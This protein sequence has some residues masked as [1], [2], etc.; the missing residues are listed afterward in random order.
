MKMEHVPQ[1]S[2]AL[3]AAAAGVLLAGC[4]TAPIDGGSTPA[5]AV[6]ARATVGP[7]CGLGDA[8][9]A[10][11]LTVPTSAGDY[12]QLKVKLFDHRVENTR[13]TLPAR[14]DEPYQSGEWC[15]AEFNCRDLTAATVVF[16]ARR[17]DRSIPVTIDARL[18]DGTRFTAT[19]LARPRPGPLPQCG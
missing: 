11:L 2:R 18:P 12:P 6:D 16:G 3:L 4:S 5:A 13:V 9:G 14:E 1:S 19:R 10:T 8:Y 15:T 17:R 7:L